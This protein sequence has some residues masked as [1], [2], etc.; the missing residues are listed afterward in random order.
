MT[1][2]H[3]LL[4]RRVPAC[5]ALVALL[6]SLPLAA[7]E[8]YQWKDAKGVTHYSDAPPPSGSY[9]NRRIN[10]TGPRAEAAGENDAA[11]APES[12]ECSVARAN[13]ALLE[14]DGPLR[15]KSTADGEA[16]ILTAEQR[17]AQKKMAEASIKA[18]CKQPE[19]S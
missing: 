16:T 19:P 7:G 4:F 15:M 11:V 2:L 3:T 18:Y 17:E 1:G 14:S 12:S 5:L 9:Q 8:L 10:D 13:L 6:I